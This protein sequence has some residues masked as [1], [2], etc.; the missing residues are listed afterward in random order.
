MLTNLAIVALGITSAQSPETPSLLVATDKE[1]STSVRLK[2]TAD[3]VR[4][5][6][7]GP[8]NVLPSVA[9]DVNRNGAVDRDLDF[10]IGFSDDDTVCFQNLI[11]EG[12]SSICKLPGE[13]ARVVR[14]RH[15]QG[16]TTILSIPKRQISGD[17]FGFGFAISLW[18]KA[19]NYK[20][21][22]AGGDY[23]FGGAL[24]LVSEGPNFT[25][26]RKSDL[27]TPILPAFRRYEACLHKGIGALAPLSQTMAAKIKAVPA[28]CAPDR[29][30]ALRDGVDALVAS[31]VEKQEAT[32][33]MLDAL[34]RLD[35]SV[36]S[37]AEIIEKGR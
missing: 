26:E 12:A 3:D 23:R 22:L 17:G 2:E 9:I 6:F 24:N 5:E 4:F 11:R 18:N 15:E 29:A 37:F 32:E 10:R 8:D 1:L 31:G 19:D 28:G 20:T 33:E 36:A 30:I 16:T 13:K 21:S 7:T 27:P 25:G 14:S 34:D 35:S